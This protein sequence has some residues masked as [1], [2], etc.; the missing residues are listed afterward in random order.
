MNMQMGRWID[1]EIDN[2]IDRQMDR[3]IDRQI[4]RETG[5]KIDK[6]EI[7]CFIVR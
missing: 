4:D 1:T 7:D 6:W 5:T 3:Q 2:Q